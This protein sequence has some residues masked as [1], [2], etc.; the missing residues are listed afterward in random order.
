SSDSSGKDSRTPLSYAAEEGHEG[1]VKILLERGDVNSDSS[2]YIG[3]TPLS[4]AARSGHEG[5]VKILLERGNADPNLSDVNC[6]TQL[7]H[8]K[9]HGH[10]SVFRLLS[11][12]RPTSR[13]PSQSGCLTPGVSGHAPRAQEEASSGLL[14]QQEDIMPDVGHKITEATPFSPP[15]QS[16]LNQL[17]APPPVSTLVSISTSKTSPGSAIPKPSRLPKRDRVTT[18]PFPPAKSP[19]LS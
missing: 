3:Q 18:P 15:D 4:Y 6:W 10:T 14:S 11:E 8:A 16:S 17:Q 9:C 12:P 13:Q 19:R 7:D 1:V 2:D 5:I